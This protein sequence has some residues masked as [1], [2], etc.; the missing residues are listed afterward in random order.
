[1][2]HYLASD[3]RYRD[4]IWDD[5]FRSHLMAQSKAPGSYKFGRMQGPRLAVRARGAFRRF[6]GYMKNMIEAVA[7]A[8]LRGMRHELELRGFDHSSEGW[9]T[10]KS[11][12]AGCDE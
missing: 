12:A 1:M 4:F 9:G 3:D 11:P 8:K 5:D 7:D 6:N 2:P 10:G